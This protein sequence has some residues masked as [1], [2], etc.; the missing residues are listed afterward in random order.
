MIKSF[1]IIPQNSS[2][3]TSVSTYE[4]RNYGILIKYPSDW[5]K[6]ESTTFG[7][8]INVVTFVSTT[9][10]IRPLRY[11][12]TWINFIIRPLL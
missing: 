11:P 8:P 4:N 3:A 5:S 7:T 12:Y 6:Q 10:P 2:A 1:E 9:G